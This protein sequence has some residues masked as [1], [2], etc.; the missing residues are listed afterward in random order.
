MGA[1]KRLLTLNETVELMN[2]F[3]DM[4]AYDAIMELA[5]R[6][7]NNPEDHHFILSRRAILKVVGFSDYL[8]SL[9]DGWRVEMDS[10][11]LLKEGIVLST[12]VKSNE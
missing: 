12:P 5:Q 7:I 1:M 11:L 6:T 3:G 10:E 4:V 9:A 8:P 2:Y